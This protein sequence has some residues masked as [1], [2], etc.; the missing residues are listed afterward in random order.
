MPQ[1]GKNITFGISVK[2][3]KHCFQLVGMEYLNET[4]LSTKQIKVA[5]LINGQI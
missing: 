2:Q 3:Q 4:I 1:G 5:D